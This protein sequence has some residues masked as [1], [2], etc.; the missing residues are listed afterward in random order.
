MHGSEEIRGGLFKKIHEKISHYAIDS[1]IFRNKDFI[2]Y[3][4]LKRDEMQI[5]FP[6]FVQMEVGFYY[7]MRGFTWE[8]FWEDVQEL[9]AIFLSW[10]IVE[11]PELLERANQNKS[12]LP[13]R[14]HLRDYLIGMESEKCSI[15]LITYNL[16]HFFWLENTPIITPEEL[17]LA[18]PL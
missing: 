8:E 11:L 17:V 4:E 2:H 7:R 13:F 5:Y 16:K 9:D 12:T 3:L 1:N 6:T 15:G 18:K 14:D 10:G